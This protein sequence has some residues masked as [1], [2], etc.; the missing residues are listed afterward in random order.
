MKKLLL[1]FMA[2]ALLFINIKIS[3]AEELEVVWRH[4]SKHEYGDIEPTDIIYIGIDKNMLLMHWKTTG[5]PEMIDVYK[6]NKRNNNSYCATKTNSYIK[7]YDSD[8]DNFIINKEEDFVNNMKNICFKITK[9]ELT[10]DQYVF[11]K[12]E[13]LMINAFP[14][15][16]LQKYFNRKYD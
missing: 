10:L 16:F 6:I 11:K 4:A 13:A 9:D 8:S 2:I 15:E 7:D 1:L 14:M 5:D 12:E 3:N